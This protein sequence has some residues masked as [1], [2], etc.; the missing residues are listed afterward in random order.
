VNDQD[1]K[2]ERRAA[3]RNVGTVVTA[4]VVAG[5]ALAA[6]TADAGQPGEIGATPTAILEMTRVNLG[7]DLPVAPGVQDV[8]EANVRSRDGLERTVGE[9]RGEMLIVLKSLHFTGEYDRDQ[10]VAMKLAMLDA[11]ASMRAAMERHQGGE[12]DAAA[13]AGEVTAVF[14]EFLAELAALPGSNR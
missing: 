7:L 14:G 8:I 3:V 13:A 1:K 9:L 11:E 2:I 12:L 4:S 10:E 6:A 5:L